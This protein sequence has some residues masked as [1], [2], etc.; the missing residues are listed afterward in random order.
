MEVLSV[1]GEEILLFAG[2]GNTN[3]SYLFTHLKSGKLEKVAAV[4]PMNLSNKD[5]NLIHQKIITRDSR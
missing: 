5:Y 3:D 4:L 2:G 1:T